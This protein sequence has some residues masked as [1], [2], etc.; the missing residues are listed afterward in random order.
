MRLGGSIAFLKIELGITKLKEFAAGNPGYFYICDEEATKCSPGTLRLRKKLN[1]LH[2]IDRRRC[3]FIFRVATKLTI[4]PHPF[5][6]E[7]KGC[8]TRLGDQKLQGIRP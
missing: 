4:K 7:P 8:A 3:A 6:T 1:N 5:E 2:W